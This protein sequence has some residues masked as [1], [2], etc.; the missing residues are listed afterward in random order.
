MIWTCMMKS[1]EA[2]KI[3]TRN[4]TIGVSVF[5]G[6]GLP[7]EHGVVDNVSHHVSVGRRGQPPEG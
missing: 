7:T 2:T 4:Y 3:T 6:G 5:T 1:M